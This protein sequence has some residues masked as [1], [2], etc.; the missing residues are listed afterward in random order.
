MKT[1]QQK[2]TSLFALATKVLLLTVLAL[3]LLFSSIYYFRSSVLKATFNSYMQESEIQIQAIED[4]KISTSHISIKKLSVAL[5]CGKRHQQF[6]DI[7]LDFA[8]DDIQNA[9]ITI[10][11]AT[12]S[13]SVSF[14]NHQPQTES[15]L[16]LDELSDQLASL[17]IKRFSIKQ[18]NVEQLNV[19]QLNRDQANTDPAVISQTMPK[20]ADHIFAMLSE[21]KTLLW[22]KHQLQQELSIKDQHTSLTATLEWQQSHLYGQLMLTVD[23]TPALDASFSTKPESSNHQ[24]VIDGSLNIKEL[25]N[26]VA[27]YFTLPEQSRQLSGSAKFS[28]QAFIPNDLSANSFNDH[29]TLVVQ[30]MDSEINHSALNMSLTTSLDHP[31]TVS[32]NDVTSN[33]IAIEGASLS[34]KIMEQDKKL[35]GSGNISS[36]GCDSLIEIRC[37]A[38]YKI[39][40]TADA[41]SSSQYDFSGIHSKLDGRIQWQGPVIEAQVNPQA[42]FTARSMSFDTIQL[43]DTLLTINSTVSIKHTFDTNVTEFAAADFRIWLPRVITPAFNLATVLSVT[44]LTGI[45]D[46]KNTGATKTTKT[47]TLPTLDFQLASDSINIQRPSVWIPAIALQS[48]VTLIEE[49]AKVSGVINSDKKKYLGKFA[50]TQNINEQQGKGQLSLTPN[51]FDNSKG[52]LSS[53]FS[54]WPFDADIQA[55]SLAAEAALN[56]RFNEGEIFLSGNSSQLLSNLSGH[57]NDWGIV[58]L[59]M[60]HKMVISSLDD[61]TS[62]DDGSISLSL[63]NIGVPIRDIS[64]GFVLQTTKNILSVKQL[65]SHL[66]N[67]TVAVDDFDFGYVQGKTL[68]KAK[69]DNIDISALM[70]QTGYKDVEAE[71]TIFGTLPIEIDP[72]TISVELGTFAAR[73]P[74]GVIRYLPTTQTALQSSNSAIQLVS[75]A[76]KNYHYDT[77]DTSVV[78]TKSGDLSLGMKM[79]GRNPDLNNGQGINL[80]INIEDNI[81]QL[82]KSLQSSRVVTDLVSKKLKNNAKGE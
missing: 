26:F 67:G 73:A 53:H 5:G 55:G 34:F 30:R 47:T 75:D 14:C 16:R 21:P 17:P 6:A 63:L 7:S 59:N 64:A 35:S 43:L 23:K 32:I 68:L 2:S 1:K 33:D 25:S 61:I 41:I 69:F 76:L 24:L 42:S 78:Y 48:S 70:N 54:S 58:D 15:Q 19:E 12:L 49:T 51:N 3:V 39:L 27:N 45:Y 4:L 57:I 71:G 36:L 28:L 65:N 46:Q 52:K 74:G 77:M 82:L 13:S 80:N 20:T 50:A 66:F 81:P 8:L 37:V 44:E 11:S 22:K 10:G 18:L 79:K 31:L 29:S 62:I 72:T 40:L 56:W 9:E 60:H 38:E